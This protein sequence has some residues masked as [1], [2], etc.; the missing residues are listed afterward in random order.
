MLR[1]KLKIVAKLIEL[2]QEDVVNFFTT[3]NCKAGYPC[4][5]KIQ[6]KPSIKNRTQLKVK[7][8]SQINKKN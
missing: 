3:K 4:K 2:T 5:N 6:R 1:L 7:P 8:K